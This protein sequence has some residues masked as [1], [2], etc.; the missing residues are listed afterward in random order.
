ME[1]FIKKVAEMRRLQKEYFSSRDPHSLK[2]AKKAESEVDTYIEQ[3]Q[4]MIKQ[5]PNNKMV[6]YPAHPTLF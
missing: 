3:A 6:A 1:E 4:G 5:D 2:A